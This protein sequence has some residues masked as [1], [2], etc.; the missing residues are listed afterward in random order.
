M[1]CMTG[2]RGGEERRERER[3]KGRGR[4]RDRERDGK[5]EWRWVEMKEN[6]IDIWRQKERVGLKGAGPME[7]G[8]RGGI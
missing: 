1:Y 8:R 3:E 4:E 6:K 7:K 2:E 5:T